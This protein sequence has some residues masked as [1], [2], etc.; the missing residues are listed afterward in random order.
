MNSGWSAFRRNQL[1]PRLTGFQDS[2]QAW[3]ARFFGKSIMS[4][5]IAIVRMQPELGWLE[6]RYGVADTRVGFFGGG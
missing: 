4:S 5:P 3:N 1:I 2:N 6:G